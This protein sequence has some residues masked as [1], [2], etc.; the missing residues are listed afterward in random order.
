MAHYL[1]A[2]LGYEANNIQSSNPHVIASCA[3]FRICPETLSGYEMFI[4]SKLIFVLK[5]ICGKTVGKCLIVRLGYAQQGFLRE[6]TFH[7]IFLLGI[8]ALD[9]KLEVNVS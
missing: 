6:S 2:K 1:E 9:G 4:M 8:G 7:Y 5:V 3:S